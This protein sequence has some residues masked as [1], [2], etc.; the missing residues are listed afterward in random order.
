MTCKPIGD[1]KIFG[2]ICTRSRQ[3]TENCY[4]CG[5]PAARLCDYEDALGTCDQPMCSNHAHRTAKDT[6]YCDEHYNELV[7][8]KTT[9]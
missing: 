8:R 1:G 5:K 2:W 4:I 6:D 3:F 9:L 7:S